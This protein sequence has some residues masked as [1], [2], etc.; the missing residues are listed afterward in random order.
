[1]AYGTELRGREIEVEQ[2]GVLPVDDWKL[3]FR[4]LAAGLDVYAGLAVDVTATEG[5]RL[6][7]HGKSRWVRS[8]RTQEPWSLS[9]QALEQARA[10]QGR[11][12]PPSRWIRWKLAG[13]SGS[14]QVSQTAYSLTLVP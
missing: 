1:M 9:A 6:G 14:E 11:C 10:C 8:W 4:T 13:S 2:D 3:A 7:R 12:R 5:P